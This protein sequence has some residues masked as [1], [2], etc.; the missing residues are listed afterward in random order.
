MQSDLSAEDFKYLALKD[1]ICRFLEFS[2]GY[3]VWIYDLRKFETNL[4]SLD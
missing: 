2:R 3:L 1:D 4:R